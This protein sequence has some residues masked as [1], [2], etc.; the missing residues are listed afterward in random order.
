ME[1]ID[2]SITE[3][4]QYKSKMASNS[5][6]SDRPTQQPGLAQGVMPSEIRELSFTEEPQGFFQ[7][8]GNKPVASAGMVGWAAVVAYGLWH[9]R[10]HRDQPLSLYL[11]NLRLAAQGLVVGALS[12]A[13]CASLG[14]RLYKMYKKNQESGSSLDQP[15]ALHE[16]K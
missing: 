4:Q 6:P 12:I 9:R 1:K 13:V 3:E 5:N 8:A 15:R 16:H 7:R 14:N 11:I 10:K 2:S